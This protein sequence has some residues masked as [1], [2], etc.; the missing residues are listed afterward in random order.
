MT[1]LFLQELDYWFKKGIA[2]HL[3]MHL[4]S[5]CEAHSC[6]LILSIQ[7]SSGDFLEIVCVWHGRLA[8]RSLGAASDLKVPIV[9]KTR[10][11]KVGSGFWVLSTKPHSRQ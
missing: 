1:S 11:H 3:K 4:I 5:G 10:I 2:P 9:V 7:V 6:S 8:A